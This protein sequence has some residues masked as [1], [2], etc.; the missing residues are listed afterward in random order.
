MDKNRQKLRIRYT[1]LGLG[2]RITRGSH[3]I[4][5]QLPRLSRDSRNFYLKIFLYQEKIFTLF[6]ATETGDPEY[7]RGSYRVKLPDGRTQIVTYE[8]MVTM[9]IILS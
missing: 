1:S 3:D 7:V 6:Q 4:I 8:V 2:T 5:Y 9:E